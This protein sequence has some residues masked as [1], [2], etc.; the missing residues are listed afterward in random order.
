MKGDCN[1]DGIFTPA[2]VVYELGWVFLGSPQ[3]LPGP[4]VADVNCDGQ[5][6]PADVVIE[7]NK[8]F[9]GIPTPC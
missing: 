2:D 5:F 9:L 4:S 3:P 1:F 7:L 6:T 8:V